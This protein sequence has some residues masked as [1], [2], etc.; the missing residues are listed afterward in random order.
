[1]R[2]VQVDAVDAVGLLYLSVVGPIEALIG[3]VVVKGEG[4][5]DV[6]SHERG[7]DVVVGVL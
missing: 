6:G 5:V 1:M 2:P 4:V 3:N 7:D